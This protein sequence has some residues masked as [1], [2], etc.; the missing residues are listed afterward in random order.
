MVLSKGSA[1]EYLHDYRDGKIAQGL[2]INCDFDESLRFKYGQYVGILGAD[3]VGK[4]YFMTWYMLALT[5]NHG[6][7]WGIWTDENSKGRFVAGFD[8]RR[9]MQSDGRPPEY[10]I[11]NVT[12]PVRI[13]LI[14]KICEIMDAP[15]HEVQ[16]LVENLDQSLG[17]TFAAKAL[18][19]VAKDEP[20]LDNLMKLLKILGH[21]FEEPAQV[22]INMSLESLVA[23][24]HEDS[25]ERI[26]EAPNGAKVIVR[27]KKEEDNG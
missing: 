5:T 12:G 8:P 7:K 19:K 13:K 18:L 16:R 17:D 26:V 15:V 1:K 11:K 3:N 9:T 2:G 14:Q 23:G 4:T 24:A 27:K 21:K 10:D 20:T 22:N 25:S 6:L